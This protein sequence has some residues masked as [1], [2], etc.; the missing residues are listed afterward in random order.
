MIRIC[1]TSLTLHNR[2]LSA[3]VSAM[4][5]IR[6][7]VSIYSGWTW[8]RILTELNCLA[9]KNEYFNCSSPSVEKCGVP[10]SCCINATDISS[11]LVNIMCGYGVQ[12]HS[13]AAASKRIWTSGCIEIVRVWAE[14]NLYV[15]AGVALG[16]ALL[17]LF[18]IYLA[19]TL[20][21]QID[22]QKSRWSWVP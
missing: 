11:G 7:G 18:V 19:K 16:I 21:G 20:E 9:G 15:I 5:V 13:V 8:K 2:S 4:Q 14:R 10:Y 6:I 22:M 12:E 1:R 17:Q 3:V